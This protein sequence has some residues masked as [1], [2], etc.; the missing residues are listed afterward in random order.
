MYTR[1]QLHTLIIWDT[2]SPSFSTASHS[3]T[4]VYFR[5]VSIGQ[6]QGDDDTYST[7]VAGEWWLGDRM[8]Q[9]WHR[10][11]VSQHRQLE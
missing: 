9:R 4:R 3:A 8:H 10:W 2:T 6:G 1:K 11:T 5:A 7:E